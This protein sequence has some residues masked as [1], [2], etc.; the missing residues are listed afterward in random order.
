MWF[1][2]DVLDIQSKLYCRFFG[3]FFPKIG[4]NFN[5]FSGHTGWSPTASN[6][7]SQLT[8]K[9]QNVAFLAFFCIANLQ[10]LI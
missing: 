9:R 5:Q 7:F 3:H 4:Q 6:W 8:K 1:D 2:V 10:S